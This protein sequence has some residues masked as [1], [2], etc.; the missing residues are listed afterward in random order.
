[1]K[2]L[3]LHTY[4][5]CWLLILNYNLLFLL[6]LNFSNNLVKRYRL[7]LTQLLLFIKVCF[8]IIFSNCMKSWFVNVQKLLFVNIAIK[9]LKTINSETFFLLHL[10]SCQFLNL[11]WDI[12]YWRNKFL[13]CYLLW[14]FVLMK[15]FCHTLI[16]MYRFKIRIH[17]HWLRWL[18]I[19][20]R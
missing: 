1:M 2:S 9:F 12:F 3:R 7:A 15:L 6:R 10:I 16:L 20:F 18:V 13:T 14:Y 5:I 11:L 19:S 8:L 17:L 4:H